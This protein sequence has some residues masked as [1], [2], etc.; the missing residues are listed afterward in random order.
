[1]ESTSIAGCTSSKSFNRMK[2]GRTLAP[3]RQHTQLQFVRFDLATSP[4]IGLGP[5]HQGT[6]WALL[7]NIESLPSTAQLTD[8]AKSFPVTIKSNKIELQHLLEIL[9]FCGVLCPSDQTSYFERFVRYEE[10]ELQQ[11]KQFFKREWVV[12]SPYLSTGPHANFGNCLRRRYSR[13][14]R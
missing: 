12:C 1:M 9:G 11:P 13:C 3:D 7:H 4:V 10:A 14:D 2:P 8:L 6:V 5:D